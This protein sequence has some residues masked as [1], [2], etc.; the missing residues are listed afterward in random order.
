MGASS[1]A[2]VPWLDFDLAEK[3]ARRLLPAGPVLTEAQRADLV[4]DLR[5]AA[6]M[7]PVLVARA[8]GLP[9]VADQSDFIIDR[10]TWATA[11]VDTARTLWAR[12]GPPARP[13]AGQRVQGRLV[14]TQ[15]GA[16]LAVF[17]TR[18]LGQ[19]DPF[20]PVPRLV[21][22]A[23]NIHHVA[24]TLN[25]DASDFHRWVA[26]HEQTHRVQFAAAPWLVDHLLGL[27]TGVLRA[28]QGA[29][30]SVLDV[31]GRL[32]SRQTRHRASNGAVMD[33][34]SAP[35][36]RPGLD[37]VTAV[38]SLLEGHADVVMD[39]AGPQVVDTLPT[40]RARFDQRRAATG[41]W[42]ALARLTGMDAKLAQYRE[43]AAFCRNVLAHGGHE[44]LNRVFEGPAMLP[45]RAEVL[46]PKRWLGR[47]A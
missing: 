7:A 3:T 12:W 23:P 20:A 1:E 38:M 30:E 26:L 34:L 13:T 2:L 9:T 8:T 41:R 25:L 44:L 31:L 28:E 32:T 6:A 10:P 17:G 46:E 40:I 18:V 27:V 29:G 21:L 43:G 45:T 39:L 22:V 42:G 16:M 5:E 4:L 11:M 33:V 19:F 47:V 14:A 24:T 36:A 15:A 35:T 37:E